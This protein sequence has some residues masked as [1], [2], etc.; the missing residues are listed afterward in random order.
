MI[1]MGAG[2][3]DDQH[4]AL[5]PRRNGTLC[6]DALDAA[7]AQFGVYGSAGVRLSNLS[8]MVRL[9]VLAEHSVCVA[10]DASLG[11]WRPATPELR[12]LVRARYTKPKGALGFAMNSSALLLLGGAITALCILLIGH[13]RHYG[14]HRHLFHVAHPAR[15]VSVLVAVV[16]RQCE[17]RR[18]GR[19]LEAAWAALVVLDGAA[20]AGLAVISA[21]GSVTVIHHAWMIVDD[22]ARA[23]RG[24]LLASLG[25][26]VAASAL[27][28]AGI[29]MLGHRVVDKAHLERHYGAIAGLALLSFV[30]MS[31]LPL[32]PW[33]NDYGGLPSRRTFD[34]FLLLYVPTTIFAFGAVLL[35]SLRVYSLK[36]EYLTAFYGLELAH[37]LLSKCFFRLGKKA[38]HS[39]TSPTSTSATSITL[40]EREEHGE[41][42][43]DM[44]GSSNWEMAQL[45]ADMESSVVDGWNL[46][47]NHARV[48]IAS[49]RPEVASFAAWIHQLHPENCK[50]LYTETE[51]ID[52][53]IYEEDSNFRRIWTEAHT[54]QGGNE[55]AAHL[56]SE[57]LRLQAELRVMRWRL[58]GVQ[59]PLALVLDEAPTHEGAASGVGGDEASQEASPQEASQEVSQEAS[60]EDSVGSPSSSLY[61]SRLGRARAANTLR[62]SCRAITTSS[63]EA[64]SEDSVA[65]RVS[66]YQSRLS[67]PGL[68]MSLS[69]GVCTTIE[70]PISMDPRM[71]VR[72]WVGLPAHG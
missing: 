33:A 20:A 28:L 30:K 34:A 39:G 2:V 32:L 17:R 48:F 7:L 41:N 63:D 62:A 18:E 50:P 35:Y 31:L 26:P 5:V 38:A 25:A 40:T 24:V 14:D 21:Q 68:G 19:W 8:V 56:Q 70:P 57:L 12:L 59:A 49:Q 61:E 9:E 45:R 54:L 60:Q 3:E 6:E 53:R 47:R 13:H 51:G 69:V 72:R 52:P 16:L 36:S 15:L 27:F 65:A 43:V 37:I 29:F 23:L 11:T 71:P 44:H 66:A 55:T 1:R 42:W 46:V 22:E 67:P 58:E 4:V 10:N 64:G